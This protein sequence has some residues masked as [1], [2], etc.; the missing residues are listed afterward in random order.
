[1]ASAETTISI[2]KSNLEILT[3]LPD[4][5]LLSGPENVLIRSGLDDDQMDP[6]PDREFLVWEDQVFHVQKW[7]IFRAFPAMMN[8]MAIVT[9]MK[10]F[11]DKH[12]EGQ[13]P[14]LPSLLRYY[15]LLPKYARQ[16]R[17]V[18]KVVKALEFTKH[19]LSIQEKELAVNYVCQFT[20]PLDPCN[21]WF[22]N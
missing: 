11:M 21:I 6:I 16:H 18:K 8:L 10:G 9:N 7:A 4:D 17:L 19:D 3:D 5:K 14:V 15:N 13:E 22:L 1:M 2:D 20:L 12:G